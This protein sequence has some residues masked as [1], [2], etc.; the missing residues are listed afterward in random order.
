MSD[1]IMIAHIGYTLSRKH[2]ITF[3]YEGTETETREKVSEIIN[4]LAMHLET[5]DY[6]DQDLR[7]Y[8]EKRL[9]QGITIQI[10]SNDIP[11][12]VISA[13]VGEHTE[14]KE[15]AIS[16]FFESMWNKYPVKKGKGKV[17]KQK[18][19]QLFKLGKEIER[20][21]GRYAEENNALSRDGKYVMHGSTFFNVGY[22]D[23][24]DD[25]YKP[26]LPN[27]R[28]LTQ[29]NKSKHINFSQDSFASLSDAQAREIIER[30]KNQRRLER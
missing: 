29:I 23:Y 24:R 8:I 18:K 11:R 27:N 20:C 12:P 2:C 28:S 25:V 30:K 21:I 5:N 22:Q 14:N 1:K 10:I 6:E 7:E 17:T 16:A 3:A 15:A 13:R 4:N 9:S 19:A 26:T